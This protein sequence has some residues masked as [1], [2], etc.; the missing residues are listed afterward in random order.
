MLAEIGL[1]SAS[2][3]IIVFGFFSYPLEL[4]FP[5]L[6][7]LEEEVYSCG[8]RNLSLRLGVLQLVFHDHARLSEEF[9]PGLLFQMTA[10][11]IHFWLESAFSLVRS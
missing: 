10:F 8:W 4:F 9:L 5:H 2:Y 3:G 7:L 6:F 11:L 1:K